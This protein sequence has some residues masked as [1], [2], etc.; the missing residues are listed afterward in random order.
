VEYVEVLLVGGRKLKRFLVALDEKNQKLKR[1]NPKTY[2]STL[3]FVIPLGHPFAIFVIFLDAAR[4]IKKRYSA[5]GHR[6]K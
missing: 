2:W 4:A 6:K 5:R 1:E 3:I